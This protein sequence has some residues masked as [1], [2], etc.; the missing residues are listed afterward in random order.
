M[1]QRDGIRNMRQGD[2]M[3]DN[4]AKKTA[5]GSWFLVLHLALLVYSLSGLFSK[6]ASA[7]PFLSLPFILFYG[8]ML[9]VLAVY[10]LLWQQIIKHLPVSAAYANK[11]VTVVWGVLLGRFFFKE[12]IS[13]VQAAACVLIIAGT[14]LYVRADAA[15]GREEP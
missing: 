15:E 10:A 13:A 5:R 9:L 14:V 1:Q 4:A 8:G 2:E 11:A 3:R 12:R 6:N 7:Q